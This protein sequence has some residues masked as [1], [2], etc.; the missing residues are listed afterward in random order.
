MYARIALMIKDVDIS[1]SFKVRKL[2][3]LPTCI[4]DSV[5]AT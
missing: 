3:K 5:F 1:L 4:G 2:Y